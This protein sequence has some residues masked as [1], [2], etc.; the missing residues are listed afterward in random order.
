[1]ELLVRSGHVVT[2]AGVLLQD[3][4]VEDGVIAA[5]GH[6][7]AE[8]G[9]AQVV[10]ATGL[11]VLPGLVDA[12]VHFNEPGRAHWEGWE[13]GS[14]GA[15]A[16]GVT[17]V[18]EMPLNS[19]PPTT[20]R[21]HFEAKADAAR[22]S[23]VVDYG[24]WGGFVED[25][26]EHFDELRRRGAVGLKAFMCDSGIDDFPRVPDDLLAAG[27]I[28]ASRL[29]LLVGVHAEDQSLMEALTRA[30]RESGRTDRRA[31][32]ES[33]PRSAETQGVAKVL[34]CLEN[35]GQAARLHVVHVSCNEALR[36]IDSGKARGL[37]VTAE[38]CPHY[39]MFS[40]DDFERM[41][42]VLKC[43]PPLRDTAGRDA[44]W[45]AVLDGR[46]D[47]IGSDHSPC[48]AEAKR[49]G[50]YDVWQAWGG[51]S[52]IQATLPVMMTEGVHR[53][54]LGWERLAELTSTNP[55]KIFNLYPTKGAIRVGG[56]ADLTL[57]DPDAEWTF[58]NAHLETKSGLSPYLGVRFRGAIVQT[59]VRGRVVYERGAIV[60]DPGY[61]QMVRP[62]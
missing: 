38:T 48:P 34:D 10:D 29:G 8:G 21:T 47:S 20:T 24:L 45:S 26:R 51:I 52:G 59:F 2:E 49:K 60:A 33:R 9:A 1:M 22:R 58:S 28:Q 3:V 19:S 17:T 56:D 41:G 12:H 5:I 53:R 7:V 11:M 42:P 35:A 30:V 15:A 16:G 36:E 43:A 6:D 61:G 25:N 54:G 62:R 44:M 32:G 31:W 13:A 50:E 27:I 55:A 40:D 39:L 23:A 46:I 4:A 37:A 57:V 14:R 18:L